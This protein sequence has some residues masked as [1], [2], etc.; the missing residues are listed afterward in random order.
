MD[1]S[2]PL[3]PVEVGFFDTV[4][5]SDNVPGFA[6]SW[7]NYPYFESGIIIVTSIREGMFVLKKREPALVP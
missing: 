7:S 5:H 2:D 6:G 3:H 4:P 1:I